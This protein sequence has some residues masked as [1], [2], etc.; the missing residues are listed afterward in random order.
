MGDTESSTKKG[1]NSAGREAAE[2]VR[3]KR[4][5]ADGKQTEGEARS[6]CTDRIETL[7]R[8][9]E[10]NGVRIIGG[11]VFE[12]GARIER[13]ERLKAATTASTIRSGVAGSNEKC[14]SNCEP[15][16]R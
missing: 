10:R 6:V 3:L 15:S 1:E 12:S 7:H 9:P 16:N 5:R 11:L 2:A 4:S 8:D 14:F 13:Y